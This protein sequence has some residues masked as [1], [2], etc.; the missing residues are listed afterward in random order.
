MLRSHN[1]LHNTLTI[2]YPNLQKNPA[3]LG[4]GAVLFCQHWSELGLLEFF[5]KPA[6]FDQERKVNIL[7]VTV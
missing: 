3:P 1:S 6:A 4:A 5:D 7:V 2:F